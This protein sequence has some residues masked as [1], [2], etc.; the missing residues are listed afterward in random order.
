MNIH[1]ST[2][3]L[4]QAAVNTAERYDID[5][6]FIRQLHGRS[7]VAAEEIANI[8]RLA[9]H[10]DVTNVSPTSSIS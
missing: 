7:L 8:M 6:G 4:Q 5:S 2:I 9:S 3:C 1:A 10:V